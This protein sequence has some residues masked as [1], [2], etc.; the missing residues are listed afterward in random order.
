M[1]DPDAYSIAVR[2]LRGAGC[3]AVPAALAARVI[4]EATRRG[5]VGTAT[6]ASWI[7][8]ESITER[9]A[10]APSA[11][12]P[13]IV[14]AFAGIG[15]VD[16]VWHVLV[17]LA[18]RRE[19]AVPVIEAAL[20]PWPDPARPFPRTWWE[21]RL[22]GKFSDHHRLAR[23]VSL[24]AAPIGADDVARLAPAL[25][26][27]ADVELAGSAIS[28]STLVALVGSGA[29][30]EARRL[31]L[32]RCGLEFARALFLPQ[33]GAL[34]ALDL[35]GNPLGARATARLFRALPPRLRTLKLQACRIDL[36]DLVAEL[37]GGAPSAGWRSIDLDLS[38]AERVN[39]GLVTWAAEP[40]AGI[41]GGLDLCHV[42]VFPDA[43]E[44][45]A[46]SPWVCLR[47]F[48]LNRPTLGA[49]G[50]RALIR[51][52]WASGLQHVDLFQQH[53]GDA[54]ADDVH[55]W[56][57]RGLRSLAMM[58]DDL[59]SGVASALA[60]KD[61]SG[62]ER[63]DLSHNRTL[64]DASLAAIV[65]NPSLVR[66]RELLA[67]GTGAGPL[68]LAAIG[69]GR[70]LQ[71]LADI[72]LGDA[73]GDAVDVLAEATAPLRHATVGGLPDAGLERLARLLPDALLEGGSFR[74]WG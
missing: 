65:S 49:A 32:A 48:R 4:P 43:I 27:V 36:P 60:R 30:R 68:T 29:L 40:S 20:A 72:H 11:D 69:R 62:L 54:I 8:G 59:G 67:T 15:P 45:L 26:G 13:A 56:D 42:D 61:L 12:L 50:V 63:L 44:A 38:Q 37:R 19:D 53:V 64:D 22:A 47:R 52:P 31:S 25:S 55:A 10:A 66:L 24:E 35:S 21:S 18:E 7:A 1:T 41:A 9:L 16:A 74:S 51:A 3:P 2:R 17:G 57:T 28:T 71:R 5:D 14:G 6:L 70:H 73:A 23:H 46:L 58:H 39:E 34:E 33:L